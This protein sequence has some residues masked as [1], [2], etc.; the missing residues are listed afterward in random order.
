MTDDETL[1]AFEQNA[2]RTD[3]TT[4]VAGPMVAYFFGGP[5]NGQK[6]S[7]HKLLPHY[8]VPSYIAASPFLQLA[9]FDP[10]AGEIESFH[11]VSYTLVRF[12]GQSEVFNV[13]VSEGF[14]FD[15]AIAAFLNAYV[16]QQ[17]C[18]R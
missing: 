8:R 17:L 2:E 10:A 16:E 15:T 1:A 18:K 6:R 11:T 9:E 13:Y 14:T 3:T 4:H 12:R 5:L 7:M